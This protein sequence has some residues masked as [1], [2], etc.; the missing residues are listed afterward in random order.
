M[1]CWEGLLMNLSY[2]DK[3]IELPGWIRFLI[4]FAIIIFIMICIGGAY[5]W[6]KEMLEKYIARK[7][8][9]KRCLK[10]K[11]QSL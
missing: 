3:I 10:N 8:V 9:K 2:G 11:N 7:E 6:F 5:G 1:F 4:Y